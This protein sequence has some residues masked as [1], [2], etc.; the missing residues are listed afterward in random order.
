MALAVSHAQNGMGESAP[1]Y[2]FSKVDSDWLIQFL[3]CLKILMVVDAEFYSKRQIYN[4]CMACERMRILF[5]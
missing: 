3:L 2:T 5:Q 4:I 1:Y